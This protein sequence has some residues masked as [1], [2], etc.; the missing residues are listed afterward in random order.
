[1]ALLMQRTV[2]LLQTDIWS[3]GCVLYEVL[4][5][6]HAFEAASMKALVA[7]IVAGRYAPVPSHYSRWTC[8]VAIMPGTSKLGTQDY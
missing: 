1:L 5:L 8:H 6:R 2:M 3:L 7:K 4:T